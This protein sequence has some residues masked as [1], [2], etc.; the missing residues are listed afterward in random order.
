MFS[1]FAL[2]MLLVIFGAAIGTTVWHLKNHPVL[3]RLML[4]KVKP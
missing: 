2:Y 4:P 1:R 3:W